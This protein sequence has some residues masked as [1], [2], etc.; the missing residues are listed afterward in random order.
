MS[1]EYSERRLVENEVVFRQRNEQITK[2][3]E[4][5]QKAAESEGHDSIAQNAKYDSGVPLHFYCEC[6]DEN[7]RQRIV[8]KPKEYSELHANSSQ[9][10]V[11][12]GHHVPKI[13]RVV[14]TT[15]NY[16]VV[17]KYITP[18]ATADHL[19]PTPLKHT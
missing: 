10:I 7:C 13:E 2:D 16:E 3:L 4:A 17:E 6:S 1:D 8:L 15:G 5:L 14:L 9:F 18:P 11:I 19:N 12:P